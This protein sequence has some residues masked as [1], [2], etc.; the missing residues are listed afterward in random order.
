ML[1]T[2]EQ[3][4]GKTMA[5]SKD[6]DSKKAEKQKKELGKLINE[7]RGQRSLRSVADAVG[8]PHSNLKYIEDGVNAPSPETYANL[9]NELSPQAPMRKKMDR[10][11][12]AIRC[13]PPPDVCQIVTANEGLNDSLRI[14]EGHTLT[15]QQFEELNALLRSFSEKNK[16]EGL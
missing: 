13:A 1:Q 9:I 11:Y 5:K 10:A 2:T 4:G 16:G 6:S 15:P 14:I 3:K 12:M 7:C 8:L